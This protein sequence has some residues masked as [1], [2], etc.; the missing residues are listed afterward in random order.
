MRWA[1][2]GVTTVLYLVVQRFLEARRPSDVLRPDDAAR[3]RLAARKQEWLSHWGAE[4]GPLG[5]KDHYIDSFFAW[6]FTV[7]PSAVLVGLVVLAIDLAGAPASVQSIVG[8]WIFAAFLFILVDGLLA[9]V[10]PRRWPTRVDRV[11][12]GWPGEVA[13]LAVGAVLWLS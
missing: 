6:V 12:S 9:V 5:A 13:V 4:P 11:L 3:G 10:T 8:V 2:S 1:T 7:V